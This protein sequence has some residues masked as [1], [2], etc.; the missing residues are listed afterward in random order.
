MK[1][2]DILKIGTF[3]IL[4]YL[5]LRE[6]HFILLKLLTLLNLKFRISNE[7]FFLTLNVIITGVLP[8]IILI[9][10]VEKTILKLVVPTLKTIFSWLML[11]TIITIMKELIEIYKNQY[12]GI[13]EFGSFK[14]TY[15]SHLS[16]Q[17]YLFTFVSIAILIF[18]M[19]KLDTLEKRCLEKQ[20]GILKIS[21]SSVLC[22]LVFEKVYQIFTSALVWV[23]TVFKIENEFI[24][25]NINVILGLFSILILIS[26][27]RRLIKNKVP[28]KKDLLLLLSIKIS[29]LILIIA[30]VFFKFQYIIYKPESEFIKYNFTTQ[31]NW[32]RELNYCVRFLGLTYFIWNLFSK[33]EI[34]VKN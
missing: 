4:C 1:Q 19:V 20:S 14:Q 11:L 34:E 15:F 33:R 29:L 12:L 25:F 23:Y 22:F 5:I 6:S 30:N 13:I 16:W 24:I 26:I 17:I 3:S 9:L 2:N 21:I 28:S 27:Y 8:I 10:L 18:Y 7:I 31:F 32:T